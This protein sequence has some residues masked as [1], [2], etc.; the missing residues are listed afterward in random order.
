VTVVFTDGT[1]Q[2]VTAAAADYIN[3]P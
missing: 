1:S 2:A 3:S